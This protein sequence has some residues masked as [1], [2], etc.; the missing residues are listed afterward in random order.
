MTT[1]PTVADVLLSDGGLAVV[2]SLTPDDAAALH[3]LH[4]HVSTEALWFRFFAAGR[5]MAHRYV[6]RVLE[7]P[8]RLA[9][10][11]E[12]DG[13]LV[14]FA[15]AEPLAEKP[16]AAEVAF[17]VADEFRGHGLGT[18]LLEHLA[19]LARDRGFREFEAD[20]LR[21]NHAM[22]RVFDDAGF[23]VDRQVD[24]GVEILRI[25]TA[26]T[27]EVQAAA[28]RREFAAEAR[29]LGRM[30][31]PRSVAVYGV[32]RDGSG[33]GA[34]VVSAIRAGDF[35]G[36]L[37]VVH[38]RAGRVLHAPAYVGAGDVPGTTD[39][40]VIAVPAR[41]VLSALE[42]AA[43]AGVPAAVVIS[44]GFAEMGVAGGDLQT[45]LAAAAR[46]LGIRV[47]GPNCLGLV[48]NDPEV[49][50]N[51]TFGRPVPPAGGLAVASQSGGVGIAL[52]SLVERAGIGL[53]FF[54][55]LGNKADV[56]SNDL[57]AAWY[58]DD[59]VTCAA[60][61]LESFGNARKFARFARRFSER[62][63]LVAVVGGR[64]A[65]GRRAGASHTAAAATPA[66]GVR[67]LFAQAGV[68]GCKDAEELADTTLLLT[69]EPLPRGE[70][71]GVLS[72]AGGLGV[73]AA[74]AAEDEGLH[75]VELSAEVQRRLTRLVNQTS[76]T[77]NPVDAGAGVEPAR[78]AAIAD[79]LAGS[80]EVD[81]LVVVIVA[82]GTTDIAD[83]LRR[84]ARVRATHPDLPL[85]AV[86]LATPAEHPA[87]DQPG[88]TSFSSSAAA[89]GALGRAVRYAEWRRTE[90]A[91]IA[92]S[93]PLRVREA[94]TL[95]SSLL[96][97]AHD[98]WV[99]P[100][101][102]DEVL[103]TY[104]IDQ[105]GEL[106]VGGSAAAAAARR[107]GFP[108]AVKLADARVVHKTEGGLVRIGLGSAEEV[109]AVVAG[110]ERDHGPSCTVLVQ[111]MVPGVEVALGVVRDPVL[112]PLVMVAAGGVTT[113]VLDDR[114]FLV[115]PF[116]AAEAGRVLRTLRTWPLLDG[117]RGAPR[118]ATRDLAELA[119]R[120]GRL[121]VDVPEVVELDLNPVLVAPDGCSVVDAK[122]RLAP[123]DAL[124]LDRPRQLRRSH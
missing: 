72:N 83:H 8:D 76:G 109:E 101:A 60:L 38:P 105:V 17:L 79:V 80:G 45:R 87:S 91:S 64:S 82:T 92:P 32:R 65:A 114:A 112:G 21:A 15:T 70:R 25:D 124:H 33:I 50:L 99:A 6:D 86:P 71:V 119:A 104:G 115:P 95:A 94:R 121:A 7:N 116:D 120:V 110:F 2:R 73:L 59:A 48:C 62:K 74:D 63:P 52:M 46:R 96:P 9:L 97:A 68:I 1:D 3:D 107:V 41:D 108:V 24:D 29:S 34:T 39:L 14:A 93:D 90:R 28:D 20:V 58:D 81:A 111:P 51:A 100:A 89:L 47:V 35:A 122:L 75:V 88:L 37:S 54:V 5:T 106:A 31:A 85:L 77:A 22:L 49:R 53:R 84:L 78:L 11:A 123:A 69:R 67:A 42:D 16:H 102:A 4:E 12:V 98:G 61:Y 113:D 56:S 103:R 40:A 117:F 55:S 23:R 30:L 13:R 118:A 10:V 26:V 36:T 57:L 18:L 27:A 44:S 43:A 19:A 66:V